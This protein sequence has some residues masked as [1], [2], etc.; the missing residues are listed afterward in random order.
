MQITR[1]KS[2][3]FLI[4]HVLHKA[5]DNHKEKTADYNKVCKE[6]RKGVLVLLMDRTQH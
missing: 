3:L 5:A 6:R 2:E 4:I 1:C